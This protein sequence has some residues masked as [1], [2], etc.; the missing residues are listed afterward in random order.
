MKLLKNM[1]NNAD[2]VID[3]LSCHTNKNG[4][5]LLKDIT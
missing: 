5:A 3:I 1:L 4:L 2:S